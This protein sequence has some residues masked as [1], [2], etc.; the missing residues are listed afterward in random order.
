MTKKP[1]ELEKELANAMDEFDEA[2]A[3]LNEEL[4]TQQQQEKENLKW[5]IQPRQKSKSTQD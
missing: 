2:L 3:E 5:K 1:E 4:E